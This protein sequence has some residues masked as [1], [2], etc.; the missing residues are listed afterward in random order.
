MN[1]HSQ[2]YFDQIE[3]EQAEVELYRAII[4]YRKLNKPELDIYKLVDQVYKP[5][6]VKRV[7][8]TLANE[9]LK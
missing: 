8:D 4:N 7:L 9:T 2:E 3:N 5:N 6:R 1:G